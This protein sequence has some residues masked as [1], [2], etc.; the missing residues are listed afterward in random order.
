MNGGL[1]KILSL[2]PNNLTITKN[3]HLD[4]ALQKWKNLS[5]LALLPDNQNFQSQWDLGLYE[6]R[7]EELLASTTEEPERARILSVSSQYASDWLHAYPIPSLGL[8]LDPTTL[9]IACALRLGSTLCHPYQCICGKLVE[10]N[11][12]HGL[13][14]KKQLGRWS[15]HNEVN[16]LIKRALVQ[17]KIPATLEPTNLSALNG[18]R[19]D[20]LTYHSWKEGKQMAWDFTCCDTLCDTYVKSSA[21]QAGSAADLREDQKSKHYEEL[22]NYM[23][24]P[25]AVE[26]YGAWGSQGLKLIKDI[27]RKI[28][29]VTGENR[30]TFYLFQN[31]SVAIQKGNAACI[32]GTVPTSEG[33]EGIFDL[34]DHSTGD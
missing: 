10:P 29:G 18:I 8:H 23:F 19:P 6:Y 5:G 20:G 25:V 2:L 28:K 31:I 11:G 14:C 26:T 17:A 22:N 30:S 16:N 33:L 34:V 9:R 4:L 27:G 13:A 7:Y 15:R 12:R 21:K 1:K 3:F 32:M 24:I